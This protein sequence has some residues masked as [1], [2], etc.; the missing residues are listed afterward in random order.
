MYADACLRL[1]TPINEETLEHFKARDRSAWIYSIDFFI[2]RDEAQA[3]A[4]ELAE[5]AKAIRGKAKAGNP[6]PRNLWACSTPFPCDWKELCHANPE[7]DIDNWWGIEKND[8]DGLATFETRKSAKNYNKV[9]L[10]RGVSNMV[11]PSELACF[12]RCPRKWYFEYAKLAQR[13]G[14]DFSKSRARF[15]GNLAHLSAELMAK[16]GS[17]RDYEVYARELVD[18]AWD[19]YDEIDNDILHAKDVGKR[20]YEAATWDM[21][22]ILHSEQRFAVVMPGSKVWLINKPDLVTQ[23]AEG[24]TVITDYKTTSRPNLAA[25]AE[26]Y[27]S[28]PALYLYAWALMSGNTAEEIPTYV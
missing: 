19:D 12:S 13:K 2:T 10:E 17:T 5:I 21:E 7:G 8:Y 3:V 25:V 23:T 28:N 9:R 26:E 15:R 4:R 20:M 16:Q 27:R 24:L 18:D 11:S 22:K 14:L 6:P 1:G